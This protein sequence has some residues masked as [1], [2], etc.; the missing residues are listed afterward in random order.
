MK[1]F[2]S[3]LLAVLMITTVLAGYANAEGEADEDF[4]FVF[5][6]PATAT[7]F[8][9]SVVEGMEQAA[10]DFGVTIEV[11]GPSEIDIVQ[12]VQTI[13]TVIAD[14]PDAMTTMCVNPEAFTD[15]INMAVANGVPFVTMD[16]DAPES[17]RAFYIGANTFDQGY[18]MVDRIAAACGEDAKIGI[19]TNDL[20]VEI[21]N[22]RLD[23][24][25]AGIAEKYP[26]MEIVDLQESN[27]DP[28]A[29]GDIA[30]AMLQT[31]P[32]INCLIGASAHE[33]GAIGLAVTELDL[34]D[35]VFTG[36][37]NDEPEGLDYLR[38]GAIDSIICIVPYEYGYAAVEAMYYTCKGELDQF[39]ADHLAVRSIE[40][41]PEN[42]DTYAEDAKETRPAFAQLIDDTLAS[43]ALQA[44]N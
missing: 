25:R 43:E 12:Q 11:V 13:E 22:M 20:T 33:V 16:G 44:A 42:V 6:D 9:V 38:T 18:M 29:A 35:T 2:L 17:D 30:T 34:I 7:P 40:I 21:V 24:L 23:G 31:Y 26:E 3:I 4:R 36:T 39:P 27:S 19:V 15:V 28:V 37:F 5:V 32:E 1:K 41:T 10:K 14:K 8:W